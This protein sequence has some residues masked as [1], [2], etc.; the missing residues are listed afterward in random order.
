[1]CI[2]VDVCVYVCISTHIIITHMIHSELVQ[3]YGVCLRVLGDLQLLPTHLR[4]RMADAVLRTANNDQ[5]VLNVCFAYTAREE[6]VRATKWVAS[7]VAKGL[8]QPH[9]I[10]THVWE[11]CLYTDSEPDL[12]IRTSGETRL[13]DFLLWQVRVWL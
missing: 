10:T 5:C 9:D 2:Y 4:R 8:L 11:Q 12:V 13:S 6:M 7:G 1:M 3:K